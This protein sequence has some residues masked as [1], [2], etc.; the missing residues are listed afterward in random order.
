MNDIS[1]SLQQQ[2]QQAYEQGTALK[3]VG[4]NSKAFYGRETDGESLD[5][6]GHSGI[7]NYEPTELVATVRA[8]TPLAELEQALAEQNQMLP[9][10]P[11]HLGEAATVGGTVACNLSGP[12][13]PYAGAVRDHVLGVKIINGKGEI[14]SFGGEV[15]K[16][17][18][19][20]DLSRL[21]AGAMGSLG[22][23]LEVSFKVIPL[24]QKELTLTRSCNI[25]TAIKTMNEWASRPYPISAALFDGNNL[26]L[27]FS[28]SEST[29]EAARKK[30]GGE[31]MQDDKTF[32]QRLREQQHAFFDGDSPL[33]RLS[34]APASSH[35]NLP[36]KFLFDWG[37]AQ[38]WYKGEASAAELREVASKSGGHAVMFRGGDRSQ[39]FQSLDPVTMRLHRNLKQAMDPHSIF[40]PGRMYEGL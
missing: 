1:Q 23:L 11:P 9:F 2:V 5:V 39:P 8:G 28:G 12:R 3:I 31:V 24:A 29:V 14:L 37:G 13:R 10:E 40:N 18:A 30:F 7:L 15:M 19:G 17:V 26:T 36:G 35:L 27:R 4:G 16:N 20:Y 38:R 32:W 21:M 22:V 33:W 34:V 25:D 6:S